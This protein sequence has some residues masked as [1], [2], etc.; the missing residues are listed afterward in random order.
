MGTASTVL[1]D[2]N[3]EGG[4]KKVTEGEGMFLHVGLFVFVRRPS[5]KRVVKKL[6]ISET[7]IIAPADHV[8]LF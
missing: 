3:T 7:T 2:K 4:K 5:D 8:V 6:T 1:P